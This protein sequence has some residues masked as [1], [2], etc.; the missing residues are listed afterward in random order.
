MKIAFFALIL[1]L[2]HLG[3]SAQTDFPL[4]TVL[5]KGHTDYVRAYDFSPDNQFI[6]T[7]GF[8]NVVLLWDLKSGK[9]I[10]TYSGHTERI[11]TVEFSLDQKSILTLGAD[12]KGEGF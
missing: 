1:L 12:N 8:D 5:Q 10:R 6:A 9:Q 7:G 3:V 11:R 2:T 4:D